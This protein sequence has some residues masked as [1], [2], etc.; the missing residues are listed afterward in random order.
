MKT[1]VLKTEEIYSGSLLLI[2][3]KYSIKMN[4]Q[5][6][7]KNLVAVDNKYKNHLIN[8]YTAKAL[9]RTL[10][11]INAKDSILPVSGFRSHDE[12]QQLY[13]T[14]IRD[15][16]IEFTEKF[17]AEPGAS[18]HQS[19]MAIDLGQNK[20]NIDSICPDFPY[21]GIYNRFREEGKRWGFIERY[22]EGKEWITGIS[23]EPWHFRYVGYPHSVIIEEKGFALE[24]YH[25][26]IRDY[27]S[28]DNSYQ[29]QDENNDVKL[30][31][32]K[33]TD[34]IQTLQIEDQYRS[35]VSGNNYDGFVITLFKER[36]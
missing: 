31:F 11:I 7:I 28:A 22:K 17:V 13:R 18:E 30:F 12:Q 14:S 29:Y 33:S 20:K 3:K 16:G 23:K 21:Y 8:K 25:D 26:F 34:D 4:E 35:E 24:E 36:Q 6:I 15:N 2:N 5:E 19:G 27:T 9:R 1:I 32:I 10:N